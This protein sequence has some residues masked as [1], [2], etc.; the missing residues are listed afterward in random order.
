MSKL[1]SE[2]MSPEVVSVRP[3]DTLDRVQ[4]LFREHGF[5]HLLVVEDGRLFGVVSDRDLLKSTNPFVG[6]TVEHDLAAEEMKKPVREIVTRSPVLV[7]AGERVAVAARIMLAKDVTCLPVV[8][9]D[10]RVVGIV[11][12]RDMLRQLVISDREETGA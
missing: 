8:A 5:H 1:V 11:T 9:E 7:A 12:V 2:I 6:R 10:R 3:D 4:E